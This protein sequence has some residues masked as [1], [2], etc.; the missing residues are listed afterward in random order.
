MASDFTALARTA[1]AA[2]DAKKGLDPVVLDVRGLSS[3]TDFYIIVS[4]T[5]TPHLKALESEVVRALKA[6]GVMRQRSSGAPESGWLVLDYFGLVVHVFTSEL[7]AYYALEK[8]WGDAPR[9]S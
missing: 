1:R 7:R 2:L 6:E 3:V 9:I 4:G 5:S 8:L